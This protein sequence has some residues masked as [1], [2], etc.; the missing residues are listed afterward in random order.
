MGRPLAEVPDHSKFARGEGADVEFRAV[1]GE[2]GLA[3]KKPF[4][5]VVVEN[6]TLN[7][8]DVNAKTVRTTRRCG[9]ISASTPTDHIVRISMAAGE[10]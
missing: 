2:S 8:L 4:S 7:D 3:N 1:D 5:T 6:Q 10:S 9:M